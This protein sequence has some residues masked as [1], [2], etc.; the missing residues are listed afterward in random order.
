M[1]RRVAW[2]A[3][4]ALA[5]L[6]SANAADAQANPK[7]GK[8]GNGGKTGH[9]APAQ[10][11][12]GA[13]KAAEKVVVPFF[14]NEKCPCGKPA[15]RDK[16]VEVEGQRIYVCCDNCVD[17]VKKDGPAMLAKA[18]VNVSTVASKGCATCGKAVDAASAKTAV[19]E[20]R[21]V[22]LCCD[23]CVAA[24]KKNPALYLV[25]ATW[26][27]ARDAKNSSDPIDGKPVVTG[28]VAIY[29]NHLVHFASA[30]SIDAFKKDPETTL[31]KL[32]LN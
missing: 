8:S 5:L 23:D 6:F 28:V 10:A 22:Q 4:P 7:G 15:D 21:R 9:A 17:M 2:I 24:F 26:P 13:A 29:K 1:I 32:K 14:G 12:K 20:G 27:D 18:Y 16:F 31:T 25:K 11:D 3:L 30:K 19:F